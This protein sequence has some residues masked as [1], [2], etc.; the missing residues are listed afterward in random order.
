MCL[1]VSLCRGYEAG[2]LKVSSIGSNKFSF[3]LEYH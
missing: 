1:L 2:L 3:T